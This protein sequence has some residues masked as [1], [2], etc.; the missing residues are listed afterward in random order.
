M[1][2]NGWLY[3]FFVFFKNVI[4]PAIRP[5]CACL[6]SNEIW[7]FD[8]ILITTNLDSAL[9]ATNAVNNAENILYL[10]DL[11]WLRGNKDYLY[12]INILRKPNLKVMARSESHAKAIENYANIKVSRVVTDANILGMIQ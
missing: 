2:S 1:R 12:N 11:E 6:N 3:D 10:W 8:G 7:S 9:T 4:Q 5:H